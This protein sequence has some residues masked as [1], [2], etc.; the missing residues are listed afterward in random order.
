M[1][2]ILTLVAAMSFVVGCSSTPEATEPLATASAEAGATDMA[3]APSSEPAPSAEP[4]ASA[5]APAPAPEPAA[6]IA[7]VPM[8]ITLD[9][10][11]TMELKADK[12]VYFKGKKIAA[13]E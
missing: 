8:R 13:F 10:K 6:D 3:P 9:P 2:R 11:T 5:P 4:V 12:G 1:K 7:V